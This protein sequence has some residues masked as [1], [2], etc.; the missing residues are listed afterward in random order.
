MFNLKEIVSR[1]TKNFTSSV[2][3]F[4]SGNMSSSPKR[5]TKGMLNAYNELPWLRAILGKIS[6]S[7]STQQWKVFVQ[8]RDGKPV[9]NVK[10]NTMSQEDRSKAITKGLSKGEFEE[11]DNHPILEVLNGGNKYLPGSM[12]LQVAQIHIDS[13]GGAYLWK[14]RNGVGVVED[15]IP[16]PPHWVVRTPVPGGEPVFK[17][18]IGSLQ[19]DIPEEE[20]IW[21][22]DPNPVNPYVRG[23]GMAF[24][25]IDELETDEFAAKHTKSWFFNNARPDIIVSAEGLEK[26]GT[27][28]LEED[29]LQK[30]QGM[31]KR[32][33]PYF[34]NTKVSV[35]QLN[36]SFKDMN[37]VKLR[38]FERDLFMQVFGIPP[39]IMGLVENSNRATIGSAETIFARFV[40]IP[41]LE[42][43]RTV[44]QRDLV[45]EYDNRLILD[46][47]SPLREDTEFKLQVM[48]AQPHAFTVD[49]WRKLA[50]DKELEDDKGKVFSIPFNV[51]VSSDLSSDTLAFDNVST[52]DPKD[53]ED[54][55]DRKNRKVIDLDDQALI[56]RVT[57]ALESQIIVDA[58]TPSIIATVESFGETIVSSIGT[59][60]F[61]MEDP[62]ITE[63]IGTRSGN[64]IRS[65]V[66]NT[67]RKQLRNTLAQGL[68]QGELID[69]LTKR[70]NKVFDTATSNR[71]KMIA[72]TETVRAANFGSQEGMI[73]AGVENKEWLS[74]RD[75]NVRDAH[76]PS[77]GL[78]GM[79]VPVRA[80][81]KSPVTGAQGPHPGELGLAEED[82]NC[83]CTTVP[84]FDDDNERSLKEMTEQ[85]KTGIWKAFDNQRAPFERKMRLDLNKGFNEQR[86]DVLTEL[87]KE[88]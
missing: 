31:M 42:M 29:W 11:L 10:I 73:Q 51:I 8:V 2:F 46:Y 83:R 37:L 66:D 44:Y 59:G 85:V 58:L 84:K 64:R 35:Q 41:R 17:V 60:S 49:E 12:N 57:N 74:S 62:I 69:D 3:G 22:K 23:T 47:E 71:S 53:D 82:I 5:G 63:F 75:G 9:R 50:G 65:L 48:Q 21:I 78:D 4:V 45:P 7:T 27:K 76:Q 30:N 33:K 88:L 28:R 34:L 80:N 56:R 15:I 38:E 36:S 86:A 26:G 81:F 77:V 43:Q 24:S 70:V 6:R 25:M 40:L 20:M 52:N 39:E 61:H 72:R 16:L 14:Q 13:V 19:E 1:F 55:K 67:T 87:N 68:E 18:S 54:S 79:V 32:F